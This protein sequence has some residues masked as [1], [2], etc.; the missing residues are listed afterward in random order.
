MTGG[1]AS[2]GY[3]SGKGAGDK[4]SGLGSTGSGSGKGAGGK[5]GGFLTI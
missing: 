5:I 4:V 3:G 1:L 2:T